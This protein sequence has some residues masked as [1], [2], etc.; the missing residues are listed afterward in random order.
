LVIGYC[1]DGKLGVGTT[2]VHDWWCS[3]G[4]YL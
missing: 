4:S 2:L 3:Y 1:A